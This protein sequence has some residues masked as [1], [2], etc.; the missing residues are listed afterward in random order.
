M[1]WWP[2]AVSRTTAAYS[3][4]TPVTRRSPSD[5]VPSTTQL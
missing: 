5:W 3:W 4:R 2:S 1:S